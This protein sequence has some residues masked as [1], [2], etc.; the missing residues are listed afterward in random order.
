MWQQEAV[1]Y[2]DEIKGKVKE[3]K[4][5]L[6]N[7]NGM[8]NLNLV[9]ELNDTIASIAEIKLNLTTLVAELTA[10]EID[11]KEEY[12][13]YLENI[14]RMMEKRGIIA[15]QQSTT[16]RNGNIIKPSE[17]SFLNQQSAANEGA[18]TTVS[19]KKPSQPPVHSVPVRQSN[20]SIP[21][22]PNSGLEFTMNKVH[23]TDKLYIPGV[24]TMHSLP[25]MERI[26]RMADPGYLYYSHSTDTFF[27]LLN[28]G[29]MVIYGNIGE[30][31]P[32]IGSPIRVKDCKY[33]P[34]KHD[35]CDFYHD[36]FKFPGRNDCRNYINNSWEYTGALAGQKRQGEQSR[37]IGSRSNLEIDVELI[38]EQQLNIYGS[39]L[40]HDILVYQIC[41]MSI[42]KR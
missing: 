28:P 9:D 40:M 18:W 12:N 3:V 27:M 6:D 14:R 37:M 8:V 41:K 4:G 35:N 42:S 32:P 26:I 22:M 17:D 10:V 16:P 15:H 21:R 33:Y 29:N 20:N 7:K 2:V 31:T 5:K 1:K 19:K 34:C 24:R 30:I 25:D 36:P 11:C 23:I 38:N 39:Q 13:K